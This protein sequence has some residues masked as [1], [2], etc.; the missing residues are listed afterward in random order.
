MEKTAREMEEATL[1]DAEW[2]VVRAEV[3]PGEAECMSTR[4]HRCNDNTPVRVTPT[5][6]RAEAWSC[7]EG[8]RSCFLWLL[9]TRRD[10]LRMGGRSERAAP[11]ER[12][13]VEAGVDRL[14]EG[15]M[16]LV[17]KEEQAAEREVLG[18]GA[19]KQF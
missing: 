15:R 18:R 13:E 9:R 12:R 6:Q 8:L 19:E 11:E 14:V 2:A 1:G 5:L 3:G 16:D 17:A 7:T 4:Y 10:D